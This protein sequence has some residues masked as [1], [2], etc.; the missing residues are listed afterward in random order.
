MHNVVSYKDRPHRNGKRNSERPYPLKNPF[1][2]LRAIIAHIRSET[3][4][5]KTYGFLLDGTLHTPKPGQFNMIGYPGVGE[6]PI[7]FS[8]IFPNGRFEHTVRAVGRVTKFIERSN[9][10][11]E[12]FVRGPYGTIWPLNEAVGADVILIAGGLGLAPIRPAVHEILRNRKSFG[13]VTL[14]YGTRSPA[15][16]LF[17]DEIEAWRRDIEVLLTVDKVPSG[18]TWNYH[19]GLVTELLDATAT[20]AEKTFALICGPE[21][22]MRFVSRGLFMKGMLPSRVYVSLERRMKCGFGQC[23]HCQHG[24]MFVCKDGPIFLYKDVSMFPDGLL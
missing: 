20:V 17:R 22:M 1:R 13:R 8:S 11:D 19:S 2:P 6:A 3:T 24:S 14:I 21:I 23:G 10:G 5:V 9:Q 7:S 18:S 16:I 15:D 4:D 12:I